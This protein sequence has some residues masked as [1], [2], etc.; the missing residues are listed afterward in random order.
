MTIIGG[1]DN[2][3][4]LPVTAANVNNL[5]I[6]NLQFYYDASRP[7]S[8]STNIDQWNDLSGNNRTVTFYNSGGA[9]YYF[10]PPGPPVFNNTSEKVSFFR[11]DGVNDFGKF[12]QFTT[13]TNRTFSA[14]VRLSATKQCGM[15]SHCNG[16][17]VG[18]GYDITSGYPRY[19][20]Y[21]SQWYTTTSP[22]LVNDNTWKNI[23][24]VKAGTSS[25][26]YINGVLS[27]ETILSASVNSSVASIGSMWGPCYTDS[28]PT[29]SDSYGTVFQGD[30]SILMLHSKAFTQS[31]VQYNF[32]ILRSRFGI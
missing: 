1:P 23:V 8:Y 16:G 28:Y 30:I 14:W 2:K 24:W 11:F 21:S 18:E 15:F 7:F 9:T 20:Y 22:T 3:R 27:Y 19:W 6:D 17:P 26:L 12:T 4:M 32:N 5:I 31:E 25:S 10:N 29:G 13:T